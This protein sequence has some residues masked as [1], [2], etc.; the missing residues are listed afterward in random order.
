M[1][2]PRHCFGAY[3]SEGRDLG[4]LEVLADVAAEVGLSRAEARRFLQSDHGREEVLAEERAARRR[5]L[6]SVPF[7]FLNGIPAFAGAQPPG[8]FVEAFR[9]F[10]GLKPK[11]PGRGRG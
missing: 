9:Q 4:K 11:R 2:S 7:F 10:S 8:A 1:P 6:T 3:F 5:G